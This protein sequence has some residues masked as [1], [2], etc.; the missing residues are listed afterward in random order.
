MKPINWSKYRFL[1]L[2]VI[3]IGLGILLAI[4]GAKRWGHPAEAIGDALIIAG[5]LG[6]TVDG[7]VKAH[8]LEEASRDISQYLLGYHLPGEIQYTIKDLMFTGRV[9]R[10]LH[11]HYTLTE[12]PETPDKVSVELTLTYWVEN[13]TN[14]KLPYSQ[15]FY[16]EASFSP[17]FLELRC[18]STE[19]NANYRL[20]ENE[21]GQQVKTQKDSFRI[22]VKGPTIKLPPRSHESGSKYEFTTK[23]ASLYAEDYSDVFVFDYP[24]IAVV[25]TAEYPEHFEFEAPSEP[26]E[27]NRWEY[28]RVF[29]GGEQITMHWRKKKALTIPTKSD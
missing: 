11:L 8:L 5:V 6:L 12:P 27:V 25:V 13:L 14:S 10:N 23:C 17:R 4:Y 24:C 1:L 29:L 18:D 26:E 20:G 22:T 9:S 21:L 16:Q 28:P 2:L 15:Y 19:T 3:M 7:Y